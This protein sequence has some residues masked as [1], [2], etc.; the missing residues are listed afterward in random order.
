M[1]RIAVLAGDGIG[2]EVCVQGLRVLERAAEMTGFSYQTVE[3]P[4]GAEHYLASGDLFPQSAFEEVSQCD[5]IFLGA[6][7][8][9][10]CPPG[11]LERGIVAKLRFELDLYVNLR[12]I[13]LFA[14][15][16]CPLKD[17]TCADVDMLVV[18]ENTEGEYL[19]LG[20]FAR[21]GTP[22]EIATLECLYTRMGVERVI[23]Y[24]FEQAR[25][26]PRKKLTLVDKVNAIPAHDLW[27]R[28]F[29]EVGQEYPDIETDG[30]YVDAAAMWMVKN[31]EWFDVVV[32][33]NLFGDILTDL[34][35]TIQGGMGLAA[36]GNLHPGKVSMFEPIHGSAPRHAGKNI[37]N[38]LAAILAA[39]MMCDHLGHSQAARLIEGAVQNLFDQKILTDL[40]TSSG[41][42]TD[43]IGDLV[44]EQLTKQPLPA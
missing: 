37:A 28:T 5:A 18:R 42:K 6:I 35:A 33:P 22:H 32:T 26:R 11:L 17:K 43:E 29:A 9:P 4:F 34:G 39:A 7:G 8:D 44:L 21:K 10:R 31:P 13:K 1:H 23:R 27:R 19:A 3:Y 38:P 40:S 16:V 36:S 2:P 12:P 14:E 25:L 20:G 30:A 24:A 41:R 15:H